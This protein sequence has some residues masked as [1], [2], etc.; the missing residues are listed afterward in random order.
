MTGCISMSAFAS[1]LSIPIGVT[2]SKSK[3]NKF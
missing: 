3:F 1:V 2:S